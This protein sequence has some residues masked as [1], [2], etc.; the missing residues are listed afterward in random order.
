VPLRHLVTTNGE[1]SD[2]E[3]VTNPAHW[4][5]LLYE[6]TALVDVETGQPVDEQSVDWNT[7]GDAEAVAAE[8]M[9]HAD[10]VT[11]ATVYLPEYFCLDPAAAGLRLS[12]IFSRNAGIH[13]GDQPQPAVNLDADADEAARL[14]AEAERAEADKRERRKV[15]ALNELGGAATGVRRAFIKALLTRKTPPKG[16]ATFVA[17]CMARDS[18]MLTQHNRDEVT[19][20]LLGIDQATVHKAVSDLPAGSDSRALVIA[21]ALVLGSLGARTGKDTWRN[22]SPVRAARPPPPPITISYVRL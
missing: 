9:R 15:L 7:D 6:D 16:A 18:Y 14:Q 21:V 11:D 12:S 4:A 19:A 22:P 8:G 17:D 1:G 3:A 5:V 20:E 13:E 2:E 10:S